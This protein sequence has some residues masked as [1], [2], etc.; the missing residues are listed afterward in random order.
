MKHLFFPSLL[1]ALAIADNPAKTFAVGRLEA[2]SRPAARR[3]EVAKICRRRP[4]EDGSRLVGWHESGLRASAN[5]FTALKRHPC[6]FGIAVWCGIDL[7]RSRSTLWM[8]SRQRKDAIATALCAILFD[9]G[10]EHCRLEKEKQDRGHKLL[11]MIRDRSKSKEHG[12]RFRDKVRP[13]I[14][15]ALELYLATIVLDASG[16]YLLEPVKTGLLRAASCV[17]LGFLL[18]DGGGDSA[19]EKNGGRARSS[20]F[21][22]GGFYGDGGGDRCGVDGAG[23][24]VGGGGDVGGCDAGGCGD[25]GC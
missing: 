18:G 8:G 5:A 4:D 3:A 7:V 25:G 15:L 17:A 6:K 12:A 13:R 14:T 23:C 21:D 9:T 2:L 10:C 1:L 24:D 16:D 19:A 22:A 20:G 11:K